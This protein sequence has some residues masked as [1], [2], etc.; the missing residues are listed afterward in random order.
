MKIR[1][2]KQALLL[3][4]FL[5]SVSF[6]KGQYFNNRPVY[7]TDT[8]SAIAVDTAFHPSRYKP[9]LPVPDAMQ[10]V[11]P[12]KNDILS[13]ETNKLFQDNKSFDKMWAACNQSDFETALR[14]IDKMNGKD[15]TPD[16][17]GVLTDW[18]LYCLRKLNKFDDIVAMFSNGNLNLYYPANYAWIGYAFALKDRCIE[19]GVNYE[20]ARIL[21]ASKVDK[22]FLYSAGLCSFNLGNYD[23]AG[24]Y[25]D[26]Y[27]AVGGNDTSAFYYAGAI[28]FM[29]GKYNKAAENLKKY[30]DKGGVY[31][32]AYYYLGIADFNIANYEKSAAFFDI[33]VQ[34]GGKDAEA[35]YY[36]GLANFNLKNYEASVSCMNRYFAK[37]GKNMTGA[38]YAAYSSVL[39]YYSGKN[40]AGKPDD[41]VKYYTKYFAYLDA[42]KNSTR[43]WLYINRAKARM[44]KQDYAGAISDCDLQIKYTPNVQLAYEMKADCYERM[45]NI[46]GAIDATEAAMKVF[47]ENG[48]LY[49]LHARYKALNASYGEALQDIDRALALDGGNGKIHGFK[50]YILM[51]QNKYAEALPLFNNAVKLDEAP[52]ASTWYYRGM[53]K[54]QLKDIPGAC[55]D[56]N[57][58]IEIKVIADPSL[59]LADVE[60]MKATWCK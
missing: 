26:K 14:Y 38:L 11:D 59:S 6:S 30:T 20:K 48:W 39:Q 21:T 49:A 15:M 3:L 13:L 37:N 28:Y 56:W 24:E 58:A 5:M 9:A 27:I 31:E 57:K 23:K 1:L 50:G 2:M 52:D 46:S 8:I 44:Y 36:M 41:A 42:T 51:K 4:I 53:V 12:D 10:S 19:A 54:E 7:I 22:A 47:H 29:Q 34:V 18:K 16:Q 17:A 35:L 43:P 55:N 33:Y 25:L 32:G 60:K 45:K 40:I